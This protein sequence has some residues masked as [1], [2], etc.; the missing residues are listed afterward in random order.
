MDDVR[1]WLM[2]VFFSDGILLKDKT[3]ESSTMD[4]LFHLSYVDKEACLLIV[5][6]RM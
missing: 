4:F 3:V 2:D 1:G 6:M 5:Y